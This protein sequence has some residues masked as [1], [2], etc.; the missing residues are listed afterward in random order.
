ML[1]TYY[2]SIRSV[3]TT[4]VSLD[5]CTARSSVRGCA[6][7]VFYWVLYKFPYHR[8]SYHV[9]LGL[10]TQLRATAVLA[11]QYIGHGRQNRAVCTAFLERQ[12]EYPCT[13]PSKHH[14]TSRN[15]SS[16]CF[17]EPS[18]TPAS[19]LHVPPLTMIVRL[20]LHCH[21]LL[22]RPPPSARSWGISEKNVD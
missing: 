16:P 4:I 1:C 8:L 21:A 17:S 14:I 11:R 7:L 3:G 18:C 2:R 22:L 9:N 20:E 10:L 15:T 13:L 6:C 19:L 5:P 12:P